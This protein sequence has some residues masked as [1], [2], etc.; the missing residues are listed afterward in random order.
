MKNDTIQIRISEAEKEA[1]NEIALKLDIPASQIV[2]DAVRARLA[3]LKQASEEAK[4]IA[5]A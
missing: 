2:R 4:E 5:I 1:L 3:E